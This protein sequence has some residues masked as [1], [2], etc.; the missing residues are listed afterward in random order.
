MQER[1][2]DQTK[3]RGMDKDKDKSREGSRQGQESGGSTWTPKRDDATEGERGTYGSKD[4]SGSEWSKS[5]SENPKPSSGGSDPSKWSEKNPS[6]GGMGGG[7]R[8]D[9]KSEENR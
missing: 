9:K 3:D 1:D 7:M 6:Q 2:R 8:P 5:G 4:K